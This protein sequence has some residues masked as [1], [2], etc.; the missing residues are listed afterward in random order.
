MR[1]FFLK[2]FL[3]VK[4]ANEMMM[5]RVCNCE[6]WFVC[7]CALGNLKERFWRKS[8]VFCQLILQSPLWVLI[9]WS[10]FQTGSAW[11]NPVIQLWTPLFTSYLTL[12]TYTGELKHPPEIYLMLCVPLVNFKANQFFLFGQLFLCCYRTHKLSCSVI[13]C[14]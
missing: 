14:H 8:H 10:H 7:L 12:S 4:S 11:Q 13:F 6:N 9:Y 5:T 2:I 3:V 1:V